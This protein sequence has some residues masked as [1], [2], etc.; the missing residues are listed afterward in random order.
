MS[1]VTIADF[2]ML[3]LLLSCFTYPQS[4]QA[5]SQPTRSNLW[6]DPVEPVV[7]PDPRNQGGPKASCWIQVELFPPNMIAH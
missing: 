5:T 6:S 1:G 3:H 4:A 7:M 2:A